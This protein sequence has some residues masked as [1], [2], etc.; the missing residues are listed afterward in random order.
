GVNRGNRNLLDQ[1]RSATYIDSAKQQLNIFRESHWL[2]S[3][4]LLLSPELS[5]E[6]FASV[7]IMER[8]R[9]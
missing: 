9:K 2:Y 3:L 4:G 5:A 7:C 1:L 6:L 8:V